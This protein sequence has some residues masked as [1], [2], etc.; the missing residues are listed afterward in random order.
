M[1]TCPATTGNNAVGDDTA[2]G[3]T[4]RT[5]LVAT[6]KYTLW[7]LFSKVQELN[8]IPGVFPSTLING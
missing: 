4:M 3:L 5:V 7:D 6:T 2:D 8:S 1:C